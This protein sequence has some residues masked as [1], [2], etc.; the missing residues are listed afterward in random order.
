MLDATDHNVCSAALPVVCILFSNCFEF[1][2]NFFD[3]CRDPRIQIGPHNGSHFTPC[4]AGP[5]ADHA[6]TACCG[7]QGEKSH[8][9]AM[10]ICIMHPGLLTPGCSD[11]SYKPITMHCCHV[12]AATGPGPGLGLAPPGSPSPSPSPSPAPAP[13]FFVPWLGA[14]SAGRPHSPPPRA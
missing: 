3:P 11:K 9:G 7:G 6:P 14:S 4:F 1:G 12:S 10:Q 5:S 8:T 13:A 2:G